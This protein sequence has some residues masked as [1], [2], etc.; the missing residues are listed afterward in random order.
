MVELDGK[1][2]LSASSDKAASGLL[3]EVSI[4]P[5]K[6]PF[7]RWRWKVPQILPG[8]N[9]LERGADDSPARLIVSFDGDLEKLDVDDRATATM[10]KLFSGREMPYATLMYV[11]DNQLPP[12]SLIDNAYSTRA[13]M[14]V[15]ETGAK[16][17]GQWLDF[18]RDLINDFR[19]A[20][21][22]EPG[23]IIS[24]GVMT[25]SNRTESQAIAYYGDIFLNNKP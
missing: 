17:I 5:T 6:T 3:Q 22:E 23:K 14:I 1:N 10:V 13:K 2:V 24:I 25:D 12:D 18:R 8:A 16:R 21:G 11:W 15:V 19:R 7:L 20:F 9:L 4:D